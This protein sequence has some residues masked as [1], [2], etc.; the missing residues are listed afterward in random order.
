LIDRQRA[1]PALAR[2]ASSK[3]TLGQRTEL[4]EDPSDLQN[5]VSGPVVLLFDSRHLGANTGRW[6]FALGTFLAATAPGIGQ[7]AGWWAPSS[8]DRRRGSLNFRNE[9]CGVGLD[10]QTAAGYVSA[11]LKPDGAARTVSLALETSST[12]FN[13][14]IKTDGSV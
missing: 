2:V 14:P 1:G 8:G 7:F 3:Q 9:C 11:S 10:I 13:H 6:A 5:P 4:V 12:P